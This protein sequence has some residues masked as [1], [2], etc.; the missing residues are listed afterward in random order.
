MFI[1]RALGQEGIIGGGIGCAPRFFSVPAITYEL[2]ECIGVDSEGILTCII[3]SKAA[4]STCKKARFEGKKTWLLA[5]EM[6]F[7]AYIGFRQAVVNAE[8][9]TR[10]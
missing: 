5:L 4:P 8:G 9:L 1:K 10:S 7:F 3:Q 6:S 2:G